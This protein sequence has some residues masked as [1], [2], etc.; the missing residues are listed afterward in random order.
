MIYFDHAATSK[1]KKEVLETF[2]DV[3]ENNFA[4]VNSNHRLGV[5]AKSRLERAREHILRDF[6]LTN[7][8]L[9][10]VSSS[11]EANNLAIIG[12]A[13]K[14]ATR[15]KHLITTSVEHPSVLRC[16]NVLKNEYGFDVTILPV[17]GK[18]KVKPEDLRAAMRQSTILVSIM[19]INNEVGSI[20]PISEIAKIVHAYPKAVLHVDTT[21]AIGKLRLNYDEIDMFVV[22]GHKIGGIK[23]SGCLIYRR[24]ISF[25]PLINGGGQENGNRSGTIANSLA[26]SLSKAISLALINQDKNIRQVSILASLLR[27][28]LRKKENLLVINSPD[29][30]SPYITNFSMLTKKGA[31]VTEA[32]SNREIYVGS[33]SACHSRYEE[34]SDVLLNMGKSMLI[35]KNSIR[36]SLDETNQEE[37]IVAFLHILDEIL[38]TIR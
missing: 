11:T 34:V 38:E 35:A 19:A 14:Y 6:K 8:Q 10:F 12:Y 36:I 3:E 30:A 1:T 17:D 25:L 21:Q 32:L 18:G 23:G 28:S 33:V 31:V 29:D 13:K 16:F 26:I 24:N 20:N 9:V 27:S 22:S 15:G 4:N 5:L 2:L 7:H 37:E